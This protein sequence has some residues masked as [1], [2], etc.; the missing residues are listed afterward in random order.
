MKYKNLVSSVCL[1]VA[2]CCAQQAAQARSIAIDFSP[3]VRGNDFG[4]DASAS[5]VLELTND[6]SSGAIDLGFTLDWGLGPVSNVFINENGIVSFGAALGAYQ[7]VPLA[8]LVGAPGGPT[9][10]I[11]PYYADFQSNPSADDDTLFAAGDGVGSNDVFWQRGFVDINHDGDFSDETAAFRVTWN[12]MLGVTGSPV[13]TQLYLFSLGGTNF[14]MEFM[15]G[16]FDSTDVV[17]RNGALAGYVLGD[18]AN[19]IA[20]DF[21]PAVNYVFLPNGTTPPATTVAEPSMLALLGAVLLACGLFMRRGRRRIGV[22]T[23]A[24][25]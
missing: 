19:L 18:K 23:R 24:H 20:G 4:S 7:N 22:M 15:Y 1:G 10:V 2:L 8:D 12:G 5:G 11:A 3:S 6:G 14:S 13:F 17:P 25:A 16:P 9:G 21:D